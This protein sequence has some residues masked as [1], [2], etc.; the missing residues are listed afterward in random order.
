MLQRIE[1]LAIFLNFCIMYSCSLGDVHPLSKYIQY[2]ATNGL[3]QVDRL[4]VALQPHFALDYFH[5]SH[6]LGDEKHKN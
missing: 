4:L 1:F 5:H 3:S 6:D 2:A